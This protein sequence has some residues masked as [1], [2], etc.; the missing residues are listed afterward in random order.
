MGERR[1][2]RDRFLEDGYVVVRGVVPPGDLDA[3][4]EAYERLVDVQRAIWAES[5]AEGEPPGGM[6]ETHRQPRLHL[7]RQPLSQRIDRSTARAVEVWLGSTRPDAVRWVDKERD[8]AA[9]AH[10]MTLHSR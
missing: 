7:S 4:R 2:D 8:Y 9:G 6:W 1:I 5:R 3:V 10:P